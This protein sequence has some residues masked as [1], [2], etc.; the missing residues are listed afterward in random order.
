METLI[1]DLRYALITIRRAPALTA[2]VTDDR[3]RIRLYNLPPGRYIVCAET[4][5]GAVSDAAGP[6]GRER[7][8]RTCYPSAVGAAPAEPVQLERSDIE[9]LEI[10]MRRG[11]TFTVSGTVL[12]SSGTPASGAMVGFSQFTRN[13][14]SSGGVR[15][16]GDGR[17][18]VANVEPGDYAIEAS[19]GGPHRPEQ[20]RE[21]EEAYTPVH[22]GS[23]DVADVVV[24][25]AKA[26]EVA[27]RIT[28]EDPALPLPRTP[29]YAPPL[30][31]ARLAGDRLP[32][33]GSMRGGHAGDDRVFYLDRMFGQRTL[34]VANVPRGWYVKSIQYEG[35]EIID[36]A[37]EFKASRDPSRL[38]IVLS[39]RGAVVSGRVVDE[40]GEA[41][42]GARVVLFPANPA[43][44]GWY[45]LMSVGV[46]SSGAFRLG[47]QR[48]G[49]YLVV[50]LDP[51]VPTPEP[52]DRD[53]L[54]RLAE[55]AERI[56]LNDNEDRT[57]DLRAVR[58]LDGTKYRDS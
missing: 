44:W 4:G 46:S 54:A 23:S 45:E 41:V 40:R 25:M 14:S 3:G 17:F 18:T 47:P 37:T 21:L 42:R 35:K 11:R 24:S 13:S 29:G 28:L 43:R 30:I 34:E 31:H 55:G 26:V 9:D 8:L 15:V 48:G 36:V 6:A 1:R 20:R 5:P 50:A 38:E 12:D 52:G 56:R 16:E 22:V 33:S 27:G 32:G 49:D 7:F 2:T 10:R 58:S 39:T 51:S 57:L 19:V 53:R